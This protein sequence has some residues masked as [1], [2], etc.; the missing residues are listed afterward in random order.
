MDSQLLIKL[1]LLAG[2]AVVAL[3][4]VWPGRGARRMALRRISLLLVV[5]TAAVAVIF[6]QLAND[7]AGLFGVG[8][9]ADLLLYGL[10][11]AFV[12]YVIATRAHHSRVDLQVTELARAQALG[13]AVD[14]GSIHR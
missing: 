1:V 14:A 3:L 8:R 6:P 10:V 7:V 13:A 9:G 2:L 5:V 11:V 12:G 4:I